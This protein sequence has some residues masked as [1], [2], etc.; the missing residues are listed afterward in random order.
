MP[1][2]QHGVQTF[3]P[4]TRTPNELA[5]DRRRA[6]RQL[7]LFRLERESP[8]VVVGKRKF[9]AWRVP[10]TPQF[11]EHARIV[12]MLAHDFSHAVDQLLDAGTA[13]L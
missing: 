2:Y 6:A 4:L 12:A 8:L 11:K 13:A 9:K 1:Q 5:A 3:L 10:G 7:G